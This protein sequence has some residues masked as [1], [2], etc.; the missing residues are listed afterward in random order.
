MIVHEGT[1][2]FVAM[3]FGEYE[4]FHIRPVGFEVTYRTAIDER[5][6]IQWAFISGAS[7]LVTL[8]MGYL[9]LILGERLTRLP[10]VFL[11]AS[12]FYLTM[13]SLLYDPFNLSVGPFIYGGD[14]NGITVGLGI[15]RYVIQAIFLVVLFVNRELVAQKLFPM[16]D[17][18]VKHVLFR[19]L[20]RWKNRTQGAGQ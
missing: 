14:A 5:S 3:L 19:P 15:N 10:S 18:Q 13:L 2:A 8:L 9:L 1:H 20:V 4:A 12:I 6:G 7:N 17:V 11:R 16:Y